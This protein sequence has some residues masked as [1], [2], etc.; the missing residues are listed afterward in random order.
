MNL[1]KFKNALGQMHAGAILNPKVLATAAITLACMPSFAQKGFDF[2]LKGNIQTTS[3]INS[4]DQAA[5]PELDYKQ[6]TTAAFGV[7]AGYSFTNHLGLEINILSSKQGQGYTGVVADINSKSDILLS[8]YFQQLAY[9]DSIK[10]TG[11]YTARITTSVIKI[12]ILFRY[13]GNTNN[14]V[15]F[16]S[17]IGPQINL[18]S[19]VKYTINGQSASFAGTGFDAKDLYKKTTMDIAFGVGAGMNIT[20]NISLS[21][22]L[23]LDYGLGDAEDKSYVPSGGSDKF[24][25]AGRANTN[26]ATGGALISL[27]YKLAKK[28]K[29]PAKKPTPP[30]KPAPGK[31]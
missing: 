11:T 30:A 5:G 20:D 1:N 24:W 17:F 9:Y 18:L 26:N 6:Y 21:L 7:S 22:H 31:K 19:S 29:E 23:R 12:P 10:F 13:T 14:K 4:S 3:M 16:S 15:Y 28:A 8:S 27:N 2:G 25:T